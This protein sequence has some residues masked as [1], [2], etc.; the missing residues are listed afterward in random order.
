MPCSHYSRL[1]SLHVQEAPLDATRLWMCQLDFPHVCPPSHAPEWLPNN[2]KILTWLDTPPQ[3]QGSWLTQQ[4]PWLPCLLQWNRNLLAFPRMPTPMAYT[5]IPELTSS[6]STTAH[7][8]QHWTPPFSDAVARTKFDPKSRQH[9]DHIITYL[10][11]FVPLFSHQCSIG[12]DQLFYGWITTS[13]AAYIDN[14]SQH[15]INSTIFY[16]RV[17]LLIWSYILKSWKLWNQALRSPL[18]DDDFTRQALEP[19]VQQIFPSHRGR[20][21]PCWTGTQPHHHCHWWPCHLCNLCQRKEPTW[22][23]W[24]EEVQRHC[25]K[26]QETSQDG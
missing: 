3:Q 2:T 8:W 20:S 22:S 12:W 26:G 18:P 23:R 10:E 19:Q 6:T 14:N 13:W 16:S 17:I 1:P 21:H 4:Q 25:K 7:Q 24:L 15:T 11:P 5:V 9:C